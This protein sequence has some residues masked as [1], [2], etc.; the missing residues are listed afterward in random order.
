MGVLLEIDTSG[1]ATAFLGGPEEL[2]WCDGEV[3][4]SDEG[5]REGNRAEE[6]H[7]EGRNI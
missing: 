5:K 4:Q 2:K 7:G 1:Y 6:G 3:F